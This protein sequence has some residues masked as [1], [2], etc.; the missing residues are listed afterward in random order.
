MSLCQAERIDLFV[1]LWHGIPEKADH[2]LLGTSDCCAPPCF[3]LFIGEIFIIGHRTVWLSLLLITLDGHWDLEEACHKLRRLHQIRVKRREKSLGIIA[4]TFEID[5]KATGQG[6][7]AT[8]APGGGHLRAKGDLTLVVAGKGHGIDACHHKGYG[9][10]FAKELLV[11]QQVLEELAVI[12]GRFLFFH[13]VQLIDCFVH[14]CIVCLFGEFGNVRDREAEREGAKGVEE[15]CGK[16]A[17][18]N[19]RDCSTKAMEGSGENLDLVVGTGKGVVVFDGTV[20]KGEDVTKTLDLPVGH[21]GKGGE[22]T[23]GGRGRGILDVSGEQEALFEYVLAMTLVHPDKDLSSDD[24][25]FFDVAC[26]VSP[27][28]EFLLGSHVGLDFVREAI[29]RVENLPAH[30]FVV[31]FDLCDVPCGGIERLVFEAFRHASGARP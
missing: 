21:P 31:S 19:G 7:Q 9:K 12:D 2:P 8:G 13:I 14:Y 25:S 6:R 27:I 1:W 24:H 29:R 4:H 23:G 18:R 10:Y 17:A 5:S 11:F 28:D 20:G 30:E 22:A 15:D 3:F 26:T 16:F